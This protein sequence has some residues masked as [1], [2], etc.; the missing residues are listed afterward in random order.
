MD[1]FKIFK[2]EVKNQLNKRIKSVKS[3]CSGE[4]YGRYDGLGEQRPGLFAK[5]LEESGIIPQ[6]T[7]LS[8]STMNDVVKRR[9][10]TLKDMVR[11]IIYFIRITLTRNT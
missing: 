2:A 6:Y 11:N 3:N 4:Y 5:L 9:N 8:L 10:K 7:V 1:M